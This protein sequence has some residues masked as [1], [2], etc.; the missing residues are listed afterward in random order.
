LAGW[1][2]GPVTVKSPVYLTTALFWIY[3]T[4]TSGLWKITGVV[5]ALMKVYAPVA[6]LLLTSIAIMLLPG[7]GMYDQG[8]AALIAERVGFREGWRNHA[9]V[10]ELMTGFFAMAGLVSADWGGSTRRR[11]DVVLGG[12]AGVVLAASWTAIMSLLVVAGAIARVRYEVALWPSH[13]TSPLTFRWGIYYGIGGIPGGAILI[14]FGLAALAPACYSAWVYGQKL[15][16]HW[17]LMGP[18]GW[19]WIGGAIAI[20]LG[21]TSYASQIEWIFFGMGVVFAPVVGALAADWVRQRGEWAGV[22]PGVNRAGLIA[23][24]AGLGIAVAVEVG[25]A[26]SLESAPWW[27]SSAICGF[28]ASFACYS[29]LVRMGHEALAMSL[30]P[31]EAGQ[32]SPVVEV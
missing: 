22:R 13:D 20:A 5:V 12:L 8:T 16:T 4:G 23:W 27:Y 30:S 10:V 3:I 25:R 31:H 9:S 18:T 11:L 21:A 28:V 32:S 15:S 29:L 7:P 19:T 6:L 26:D 14:L 1:S 2:L 17:P 24:G